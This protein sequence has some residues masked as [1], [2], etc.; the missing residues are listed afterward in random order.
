MLFPSNSG[1]LVLL[2]QGGGVRG[3]QQRAKFMLRACAACLSI[4]PL[5]VHSPPS[6]NGQF[7]F[8]L[9]PLRLVH[10]PRGDVVWEILEGGAK[11]S[12]G[13]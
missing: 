9:E 12:N 5:L 13:I 8:M 4:H 11:W 2:S 10:Q 7:C 1:T 3:R 6:A